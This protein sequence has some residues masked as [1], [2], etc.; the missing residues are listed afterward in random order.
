MKAR[1][2]HKWNIADTVTASR[3]ALAL[4]LLFMPL[5]SMHFLA[6]YT[7]SGLTD[8]L[9]GYLARKNGTVSD[10]G[11]RLDS[12]ADLCFFGVVIL[13]L[14]TVVFVELPECMWYAVCAVLAVRV[15]AYAVGALRYRRFAPVHTWLNKL[16]CGAIFILPY[17]LVFS[18]GTGFLKIVCVLA[19]LSAAEELAI[20][21]R[22]R[23][24]E[25]DRKSILRIR[26]GK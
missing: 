2:A 17:A 25:A 14:L 20:N 18:Y 8:A 5:R 3:I 12:I 23:E 13:K 16:T 9:D 1:Q 6:V 7:L 22:F 15:A 19:L 4:V 21:I 11:A 24:Y 26:E 10:F